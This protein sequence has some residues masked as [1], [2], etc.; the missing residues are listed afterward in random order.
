MHRFFVSDENIQDN[1]IR[2]VGTDVNH[3]KNVLRLSIDDNI[4]TIGSKYNYICSI[5]IINK[6]EVVLRV[7]EVKK[8]MNE[9]PIRINLYQGLPK[10]AKM[11]TIIQKCTEVGVFSFHPVSTNRSVVKINDLKKEEKKISRWQSIAEE[12]AKQSKRDIIP[13]VENILSFNE[14][15][16]LLADKLVVVPYEGEK[17]TFIKD[18]GKFINKDNEINIVIGPEGGFEDYEIEKLSSIGSHIIS[19]GPRILRTETAGIVTASILLYEYGDLG[20]IK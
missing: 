18:L 11:E 3:I 13:K 6:D 16:K 9:S 12:A 20:V 10:S 4:E 19:L 2:I 7:I 5:E 1:E 17:D 14:M 8:K 15:L